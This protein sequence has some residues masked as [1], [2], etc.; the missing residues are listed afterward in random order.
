MPPLKSAVRLV[1]EAA[2]QQSGC[3]LAGRQ[4]VVVCQ[5]D[6]R[7]GATLPARAQPGSSSVAGR[8]RRQAGLGIA[9]VLLPLMCSSSGACLPGAPYSFT[10]LPDCTPVIPGLPI[11]FLP[12]DWDT[13]MTYKIQDYPGQ[14]GMYIHPSY[15]SIF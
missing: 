12:I 10:S 15:T 9:P 11:Q 13:T 2:R 4:S 14:T 1:A 8:C 3:S 5:M 6:G 7:T